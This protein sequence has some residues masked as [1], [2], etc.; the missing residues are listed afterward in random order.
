MHV[1]HLP[2][3]AR[4]LLADIDVA[5]ARGFEIGALTSPLLPRDCATLIHVDHLPTEKLREKYA[6]DPNVDIDRIVPVDA[7][8][9]EQ[10]LAECL[11]GYPPFDYGVASHVIEH[12]PDLIGWLHEVAEV[13]RP[14]GRLLLVVPDKRYTFDVLRQTSCLADAVNAYLQGFRRPM[15]AQVFDHVANLVEVDLQAAWAGTLV[16]DRLRH[17]ATPSLALEVSRSALTGDY[18]DTHCWVFTAATFLGL[19]EAIAGLDL[20]PFGLVRFEPPSPGTLEMLVVL[21]RLADADRREAGAGYR[22]VLDRLEPAQFGTSDGGGV[23]WDVVVARL[24]GFTAHQRQ[25]EDT[26]HR[27]TAEAEAAQA[28]F[29]RRE[30]ALREELDRRR[31]QAEALAAEIARLKSSRSWRWTRFMRA[32]RG[33]W[34]QRR[35]DGDV[36]PSQLSSS[37]SQ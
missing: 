12:V 28:D 9:G 21:E 15:P 31:M 37:L 8:W 18:H 24:S 20:M 26:L 32:A 2:A 7:V 5:T 23:L 25:L 27:Q 1:S 34:G 14:G 4:F 22:D 11:A 17:Y 36:P 13:L 29:R 16:P 10:R 3:R 35:G 30:A 19:F 33:G 6:P